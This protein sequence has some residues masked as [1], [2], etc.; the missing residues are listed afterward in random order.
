MADVVVGSPAK[1]VGLEP[2][3]DGLRVP[4]DPVE[5]SRVLK[6]PDWLGVEL[7]GV[8]ESGHRR[9]LTDLAFPLFG[10]PRTLVFRKAAL[11]D[12]GPLRP[13]ADGSAVL[14][15]AWR[16]A[17]LAPLFPVFSGRLLIR[18]DGLFLDGAYAPP[19]GDVGRLI[20]HAALHH[21]AVRTARWFLGRVAA[22]VR[23]PGR[24]GDG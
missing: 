12:L 7:D 16:S 23:G 22:E 1:P 15:I 2:L 21:V 18:T 14:E 5:V 13:L 6:S 9:Y 4:I 24:I 11:V 17:T 8:P 19:F 20:D 10:K 3:E